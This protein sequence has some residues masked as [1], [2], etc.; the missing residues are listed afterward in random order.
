MTPSCFLEQLLAINR[1]EAE[2]TMLSR[3]I[4]HHVTF[5]NELLLQFSLAKAFHCFL[6]GKPI[7][8][9]STVVKIRIF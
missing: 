2:M 3:W 8:M 9:N 4:L 7:I 1:P 6:N 5:Q